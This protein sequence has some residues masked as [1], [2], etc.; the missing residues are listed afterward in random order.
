LQGEEFLNEIRKKLEELEEA[1]EELIKLSR[2]LR[3]N[4]TRAIAAVH[5]GNFEEA[6]RK[7]KAAI[8]LLEKVKAYKKYPE[9][10]GIANDAMQE[11]A[12]ALSFFSLISGQDIPNLREIGIEDAAILTGLGDVVGELRRHALDLMRRGD[13][14]RA[15]KCIDVMEEIY[16]ALITFTFPEKLVPGLRHKVDVARQLIERTKSD[17]L[18]AKLINKLG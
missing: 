11:L 4:S 16:S 15:E 6:K 7:L 1:R 8:D 18:A 12:E 13:V 5:A 9:I 10:Y 14:S 17:L 2:E 3:I